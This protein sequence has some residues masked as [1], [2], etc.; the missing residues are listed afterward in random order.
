MR[1]GFWWNDDY[2]ELPGLKL[3]CIGEW[4]EISGANAD[5]IF[6]HD[7]WVIDFSFENMG[8]FPCGPQGEWALRD[9]GLAQ[10][11]RPGSNYFRRKSK[12]IKSHCAYIGFSHG[13]AAGFDRL[14]GQSGVSVFRD[15][16][17]MIGDCLSKGAD[18]AQIMGEYSYWKTLGVL[19]D[20]AGLLHA[21]TPQADGTSLV[22]GWEAKDPPERQL[23]RKLQKYLSLNLDRHISLKEMAIA[24]D[25]SVS[26]LTHAYSSLAGESP[27][28]THLKMRLE[29]ACHMLLMGEVI[30]D[31]ATQL[32]FSDV[33][34]FTKVFKIRNGLPPA[35]FYKRHKILR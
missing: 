21:A 23:V 9:P 27:Q 29:R 12:S 25:I 18:L 19:Y 20:I 16:G 3:K 28:E 24:M 5:G 32:G 13:E 26:S 17:F 2:F 34:H 30:K 7:F 15:P 6:S 4:A 1:K 14:V 22:V 10:L 35:Q 11:I 33:H 31:I 8:E